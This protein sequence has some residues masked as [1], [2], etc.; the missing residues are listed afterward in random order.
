M[1]SEIRAFK[2]ENSKTIPFYQV[3]ST[4]HNFNQWYLQCPFRYKL[5]QYLKWKFSLM[6]KTYLVGKSVVILLHIKALIWKHPVLYHTGAF[7]Q[8]QRNSTVPKLSFWHQ[9]IEIDSWFILTGLLQLD[10]LMII[11]WIQFHSC[12]FQN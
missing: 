1:E 3:K 7:V 8:S 9:M 12:H 6:V 2:F 4:S 11:Q 10:V 5:T